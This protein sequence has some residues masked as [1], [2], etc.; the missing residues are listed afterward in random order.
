M[1]S[2]LTYGIGIPKKDL[3][4]VLDGFFAYL[5]DL[6]MIYTYAHLKHDEDISFTSTDKRVYVRI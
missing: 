4:K 5:R 2:G 6:E 1:N 3:K